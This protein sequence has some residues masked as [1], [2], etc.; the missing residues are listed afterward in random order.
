MSDIIQSEEY[1]GYTI[2]VY[3]DNFLDEGPRDWDNLGIMA[4][5]HKRYNL[6]D[7]DHEINFNDFSSWSEMEEY[8]WKKLD[9][10]IVLPLHLYD[11]SGI[12]IKIGDFHGLLPQGH[13][14][15][16]S[17]QVGF[18]FVTK[19]TLKKEYSLK[20]ISKKVIE[21]AKKILEEE[22]VAY[23]QY[24]CGEVYGFV[25]K[26][27]D[28]EEVDSCWGCYG[29]PDKYIIPNCK[30]TIDHILASEN[31]GLAEISSSC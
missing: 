3:P 28:N 26:D 13:A 16:D 9:A 2:E 1:K 11:H 27:F 7:K 17:G 19:K 8:I 20:K 15:F 23:D 10:A 6:G 4:C 12:T 29:D 14:H 22:V 25:I 21:K 24:L 31:P 18:I 5:F 30:E